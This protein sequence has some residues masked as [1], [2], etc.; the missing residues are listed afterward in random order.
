VV[1]LV[2]LESGLKSFFA[3]LGL[4]LGPEDSGLGLALGL[5]RCWT[6]YKSDCGAWRHAVFVSV[7]Q[8]ARQHARHIS[9]RGTAAKVMRCSQCCLVS[10][11]SCIDLSK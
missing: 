10:V 8:T 7:S 4:G 3:G 2:V 11:V 6:C 5:G 9:L 1:R